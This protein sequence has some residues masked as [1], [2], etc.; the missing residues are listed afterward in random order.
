MPLVFVHGV[1]TR[2]GETPEEQA[3]F[4]NK[5]AF[6]CEQFRHLAFAER[7]SATDGLRVFAPYSG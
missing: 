4:D 1:N 5:V 2:R 3:V 6:L 7:V